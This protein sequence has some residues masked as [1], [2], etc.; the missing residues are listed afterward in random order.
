MELVNVFERETL[1]P[2]VDTGVFARLGG[3]PRTVAARAGGADLGACFVG[4]GAADG[5]FDR[6]GGALDAEA[7]SSSRYRSPRTDR[8]STRLNSSHSGESRMPSSA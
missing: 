8:K 6:G 2:N 7:Y 3:G 4:I 5:V 1:A